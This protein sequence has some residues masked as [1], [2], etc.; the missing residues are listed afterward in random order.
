MRPPSRR[1]FARRSPS[2]SSGKFE[3]FVETFEKGEA[4]KPKRTQVGDG[5][6]SRGKRMP[7]RRVKFAY[8]W[9]IAA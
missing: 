7:G 1:W 8:F 5:F 3:A 6:D 2:S 4:L 9:E